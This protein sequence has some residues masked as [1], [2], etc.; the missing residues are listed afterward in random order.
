[1]KVYI[2]GPITGTKG[3]MKRFADAEAD[4]AAAGY[5]PINPAKVN[6]MLPPE[7]S[8]ADYMAT[9]IAMLSICDVIYMLPGWQESRG[10]SIEFEYAYSNGIT[11]C[12]ARQQDKEA[13]IDGVELGKDFGME[14]A[15]EDF[16]E[17]QKCVLH[18]PEMCSTQS[19]NV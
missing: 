8:H 14:I 1:M 2:S 17:Y 4:I 19:P 5:T 9:S 16:K 3:Y 11:I 10:C 6:A 7:L 12:F 18:F 15:P 13:L